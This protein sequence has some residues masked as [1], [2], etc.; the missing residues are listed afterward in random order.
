MMIT[1][2]SQCKKNAIN[3]TRRILDSVALRI[4]D[5]TWQTVITQEGLN[6]VRRMLNK[7]ASR[8]TAV[9]CHWQ[10]SRSRSDLVW[11]VGNKGCFN[12]QGAVAVN[13]TKKET[14]LS[15]NEVD[16]IYYPLIEVLSVIAALFHD[17]GKA[18][19]YFQDKLTPK[20]NKKILGDPLRHEW[21]SCLIFNAFVNGEPD[22]SWLKR[23]E[24]GIFD[25]A[26][27]IA[28]V[29]K[30]ISKPLSGLPPIAGVISWLILTHHRLPLNEGKLCQTEPSVDFKAV[31]SRLSK[32]WGYD[33]KDTYNKLVECL[34]FSKGLPS[35]S[36]PWL[37]CA[38]K[39]AMEAQKY[40]YLFSQAQKE[41]CLRLIL[42]YARLSLMLGD[43]HYSSKG[44]NLDDEWKSS[45]LYANTY[46]LINKNVV[47]DEKD[48][49]K[50][51]L[52][53]HLFY[54]A[55]SARKVLA[56]LPK[57]EKGLPSVSKTNTLSKRS[58]EKF[59]WQDKAVEEI[60]AWKKNNNHN[61]DGFFAV[62]MASTGCGKTIANAKIMKVLAKN[63]DSFR[64]TLA[65]G[66]RTLTLQT[67]DA[68]RDRIGL[69]DR[70]L[71]VMIGSSVVAELHHRKTR[72][73]ADIVHQEDCG[74]ESIESLLSGDDELFYDGE[75]APEFN[76]I[77]TND[78]ERKFLYSPVL[79]CTIDHIMPA[80]ECK[81]GGRY[82]LPT[83]RMMSTDLVI[84]EIDD[85]E[86]RDL[87]AIGRLIHLAGMLGRKVMISSATIPPDL[88]IGYFNIYREGWLVYATARNLS[89]NVGCA[90]IGEHGSL[91]ETIK[92]CAQSL[93]AYQANHELFVDKRIKKLL[94]APIK[95]IAEIIL[96]ETVFNET[97]LTL[98]QKYFQV[99]KNE[100][101]RKHRV[102]HL[103][104]CESQK[105]VS[106][107]VVR[108]ANIK[109][110]VDLT[111]FL[112]EADWPE[113]VEVRIMAYHSRQVLLLRSEQEKHLDNI[114]NR[115]SPHK[116]FENDII[117]NH[118]NY[119]S[120]KN[121]IFIL[122]ATPVEEVGR[123]H[124]FDWAVIEPSSYRSIIQ[125]AGRV[126]RHRDIFPTKPNI[127]MMQYNLKGIEKDESAVVF[128]KP[129]YEKPFPPQYKLV[130][131]KLDELIT[132]DE[133]SSHISAIPRI[134]KNETL[135]PRKSLIDLE[136]FTMQTSLT[137]YSL[138]GPETMQGWL[139]QC[140][141]MTALP[142]K[143][144]EFRKEQGPR[145]LKLKRSVTNEFEVA[146]YQE[147]Q[148]GVYDVE[149]CGVNIKDFE[150]SDIAKTRL[151]L[152]RD[153][154]QSLTQFSKDGDDLWRVSQRFGEILLP[155][156]DDT[157]ETWLYCDNLGLW[158]SSEDKE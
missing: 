138:V 9:A 144:N 36:E 104:D 155:A 53:E 15:E 63:A 137:N 90:W 31:F 66:L 105:N 145:Q 150:L 55:K 26:K 45:E 158:K 118:I 84:D 114:L 127:A 135:N 87:I 11:V 75:E 47:Q 131:H 78:R 126:L 50:Q 14:G 152:D 23:L 16:W 77:L 40:T 156:S 46:S 35:R 154:L 13:I 120:A 41:G 113:D 20:R 7:T 147:G 10:R 109:P 3:K 125:M 24:N 121:L 44:K 74:S 25:E 92:N 65:L 52:D 70:D 69:T 56:L 133:N 102:H 6:A 103:L 128:E 51:K 99:I 88:A 58:P 80:T 48:P 2:V 1:F 81:R 130:T 98:K 68:Y 42:F 106:I 86:T 12:K 111:K 60:Q 27:L 19:T 32:D 100:I 134:K 76:T 21:V 107:G 73:N 101:V 122:V 61:E 139:T 123:D 91:V 112:L 108:V 18:N 43:H 62:N 129:G 5:F 33:N 17:F 83:L 110:C 39:W 37:K 72:E 71:A 29:E 149:V 115:N 132:L 119:V 22:E 82:I 141:W 34:K 59:R 140:W 30:N 67:G 96:C 116:I 57:I 4:G 8:N 153:Y 85:F 38:K 79:V 157:T 49:R 93:K 143:M 146:F 148:E 97:E 117:K 28:Q 142:Q 95:R 151:W 54:V 136:H 89:K 94:E 64:Y 124:D